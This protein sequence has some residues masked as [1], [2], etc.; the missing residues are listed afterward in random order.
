MGHRNHIRLTPA[1]CLAAW[2]PAVAA[3]VIGLTSAPTAAAACVITEGTS[4]VSAPGTRVGSN[5]VRFEFADSPYLGVQYD[6]CRNVL[7]VFYGGYTAITHYNIR[8]DGGGPY[9]DPPAK[10]VE[11]SPGAARKWSLSAAP[12]QSADGRGFLR[13]S[14]AVQACKR[15]SGLFS[16]SSCT[17]WSPLVGVPAGPRGG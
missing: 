13:V 10:Q 6:G 14:F 9:V 2:L 17:R 4:S 16:S 11:V 7:N 5:P 15:G 8:Y 12:F 3:T 1:R